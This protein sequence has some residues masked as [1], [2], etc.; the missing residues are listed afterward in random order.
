MLLWSKGRPL[1][2]SGDAPCETFF[3]ITSCWYHRDESIDSQLWS[4]SIVSHWICF[5]AIGESFP[6]IQSSIIAISQDNARAHVS[7]HIFVIKE[8]GEQENW[9]I[10]LF[11]QPSLSPDFIV[12]DLGFLNAVQ[13]RKDYLQYEKLRELVQTVQQ[14]F[15]SLSKEAFNSTSTTLQEVTERC[16]AV[17]GGK[18]YNMP[19]IGKRKMKVVDQ[20]KHNVMCDSEVSSKSKKRFVGPSGTYIT[21]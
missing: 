6:V 12:L 21:F 3:S 16:I 11:S 4:T 17:E 13:N 2:T 18:S 9:N 7:A 14:S 19:H 8:N 1:A 5:P 10:F 15:R 20:L